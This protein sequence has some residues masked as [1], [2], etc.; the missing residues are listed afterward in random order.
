FLNGKEPRFKF[1]VSPRQ[2]LVEWMTATD[3][4]YFAPATANRMW[5]YFFGIGL[6]DPVDEM[7]GAEHTASHPELLAELAREFAAHKFDLKYLI[8]AITA[9]KAYQLTS[10]APEKFPDQPQLFVRRAVRGMSAEQFF[11]SVATATGYQEGAPVYA[12]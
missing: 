9:S 6:V 1:Q 3:N 2:T 12:R 7:V 5:A 4:P 10:A 8:R 11:E